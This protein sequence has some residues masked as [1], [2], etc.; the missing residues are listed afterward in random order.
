MK[1]REELAARRPVALLPGEPSGLLVTRTAGE[2]S[3]SAAFAWR[4]PQDVPKGPLVPDLNGLA[5]YYLQEPHDAPPAT[6]R[7]T[8]A[9]R[10]LTPTDLGAGLEALLRALSAAAALTEAALEL[11]A[12]RTAEPWMPHPRSLERLAVDLWDAGFPVTFGPSWSPGTADHV[13]VGIGDM[14]GRIREFLT[15]HPAWELA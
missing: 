3:L 4:S 1:D 7:V 12:A 15:E 13:H 6:R 2:I 8:G 11:D 14:E 9:V 5:R 10:A